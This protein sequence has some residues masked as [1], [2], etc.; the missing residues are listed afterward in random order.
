M[1]ATLFP[2]RAE[3]S[4]TNLHTIY[5]RNLISDLD[6][7]DNRYPSLSPN[8]R[9]SGMPN[10]S[11]M[12]GAAGQQRENSPPM[13]S[14]DFQTTNGFPDRQ[15]E[16]DAQKAGA[17]DMQSIK[18]QSQ[19]PARSQVSYV[20]PQGPPARRVVERYSLEDNQPSS[21]R[22][23]D[24]TATMPTPSR[25]LDNI[26][27]TYTSSPRHPALPSSPNTIPPSI[28]PLSA[29]PGYVP[30]VSSR[31]R[32]YPQQPTYITQ[33]TTPTPVNPVYSPRPPQ[34]EVCVECAM[35]D[36]DMADVDVTSPG[37]WDR[38]SDVLFEELK[39]RE[40]EEDATG[41]I[42]VDEPPRP[43]VKGGRLTEQNVKIWLSIVR[44]S[45]FYPHSF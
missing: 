24:N 45:P 11:G 26:A 12:S 43:R 38:E 5:P 9:T 22:G 1:A 4:P 13:Q 21:S 6:F 28:V 20:L 42:N 10:G 31:N 18:S 15:L 40:A 3:T 8:R 34:E 2:S 39:A 30:P 7:G 27:S 29:S 37:M 33:S 36:Q 41:I 14:A 16:Y 44:L 17:S 23:P 32:A 25:P 19:E 35:R